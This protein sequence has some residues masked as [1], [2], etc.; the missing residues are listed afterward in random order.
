MKLRQMAMESDLNWNSRKD[1]FGISTPY[2][3]NFN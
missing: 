2:G 1:Y 3:K